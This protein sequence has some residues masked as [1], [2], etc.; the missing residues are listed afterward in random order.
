MTTTAVR[1]HMGVPTLFLNGSPVP[2][3]ISYV[4]PDYATTFAQ[5]GIRL[6]TFSVPGICGSGRNGTI[7][8]R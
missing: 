7:S 5:A 8:T 6:Y 3:I 1:E 4:G 2:P